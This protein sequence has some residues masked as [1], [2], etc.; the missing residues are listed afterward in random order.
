MPSTY[1]SNLKE[2]I[3]EVKRL[4]ELRDKLDAK[5]NK[6][7]ASIKKSLPNKKQ[8]QQNYKNNLREDRDAHELDRTM[9]KITVIDNKN[10]KRGNHIHKNRNKKNKLNEKIKKH[11]SSIREPR[12]STLKHSKRDGYFIRNR[13]FPKII[14]ADHTLDE[15]ER[16]IKIKYQLALEHLQNKKFKLKMNTIKN[17]RL[18]FGDN[19]GDHVSSVNVY[20]L[21]EIR[22]KLIKKMNEHIVKQEKKK[23]NDEGDEY[24]I[25]LIFIDFFVYNAKN[26][27]G[28]SKKAKPQMIQMISANE[29]IKLYCPK[30][31]GNKCF[32][33][34]LIKGKENKT[35]E[36][37]KRR[38]FDIRRKL[39]IGV[40]KK[41][42][43]SSNEA[44]KIADN[45]GVSYRVY[46]GM[47]KGDRLKGDS[48]DK[49]YK[50]L[51]KYGEEN[52]NTI[53]ILQLLDHCYLIT[54]KKIYN[55]KCEKCGDVRKRGIDCNHKCDKSRVSY[56]QNKI[57]K[58]NTLK[59]RK[60]RKDNSCENWVFYDL[61]TLPCGKGETHLVYAVG[62][63]DCKTSEYLFSYG[64]NSMDEFMEW[65]LKHCDKKYIAFNGCRFDFY[66]L[67]KK[68]L[69]A[70]KTPRFLMSAGRLLSLKWG[71]MCDKKTGEERTGKQNS[72][73][74]KFYENSVWDLYQ[75]MPG[76]SLKSA[77]EAFK[78]EF[79]KQDFDHK[80]MKNWECVEKYKE[81]V[82]H[83]LK[84]DVLSLKELTKK[85][86]NECENLFDA[87]PT[88]YLTLSSYAENV[89]KNNIDDD[90]IIEIPN[91]EKQHFI[92]Q[93]VY[94]GRT[95]PSRKRYESKYCKIIHSNK[96]NKNKLKKI[97]KILKESGDYIFN[98]DIN[99][100]YP[101]CMAGCELMDTIYPIGLSKW[102]DDAVECEKIFNDNKQLGVYEIK[103]SCPNKKIKHPILP[104]KKISVRKNG[105]KIFSGVEWSLLDGQ[106]VYNTVD[107]Q[108]AI[109][110]GYKIEFTGRALIWEG[111]SNKIFH[112]YIT[113]AYNHKTQAKIDKNDVKYQI[114]KL[115]M[116]SL[117]GKTLQNP[118]NKTEKIV[119][120][121]DE[122][123]EF[124]SEHILTDW[125]IVENE[126]N[127]VEY[128]ILTGEKTND[129][130]IDKKPRHLG[131]F[132]LGYSRRLWLLFLETIDPTLTK[133]ITTYQDTDSLH[134]LGKYYKK[135]LK[136]GLIDDKKLG[137]LSND[138]ENNALIF[139]EIN[140]A[141]KCYL[142]L[143]L[144]PDG[145]IHT[146][147][148][149]KGIMKKFLKEEWY[150]DH[151][152]YQKLPD[153]DERK[154]K[155]K[156]KGMK[157][158][159]K[160]ISKN[161]RE[162]GVEHWSIK[163][164]NYSRTFYKN[165]WQH[166]NFVDNHFLPFGHI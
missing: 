106:G 64:K 34:C 90:E 86:V 161:D 162:L 82:L 121:I 126:S 11:K 107:I 129:D 159:N 45:L 55:I 37:C 66:F 142:Y 97:Y 83:Y 104:R 31:S 153:D 54:D 2:E 130:K 131:S 33:M 26:K 140:L 27:V 53:D 147:M 123:E 71:G 43:P 146:T 74:T 6:K 122:T 118:I 89:W 115:M 164:E 58:N 117:Y 62:W 93:S 136:S 5:I 160:N 25:F 38:A 3:E 91:M 61:E 76:F 4:Q 96:S 143:A 99:S 166:M 157:K 80:K 124:V 46:L 87:S 73:D 77:C 152:F 21:D 85:F 165:E 158:I 41:L 16:L 20:N 150:E 56:Y 17:I 98:G 135:L 65:V 156:W 88:M 18:V 67:Q 28:C 116:N 52:E 36:Y 103:F 138:C 154:P 113:L 1:Q 8:L 19:V 100:Q 125:E 79:Q 7:L 81:E 148:K 72:K 132:V 105:K 101:A 92:G 69:E 48:I 23:K 151:E 112:T 110:H 127:E 145:I 108:N 12:F 30:A 14:V 13:V 128:I 44:H 102:Y 137:Y 68:L 109:K 134:I 155:A 94:G 35:N 70:K 111:V 60:L 95:Y 119:K 51:C 84:Y 59:I 133:Y 141:P 63:Y 29:M 49:T 139:K 120:T 22:E 114:A 42:N 78:T 163:Q 149:S 32:D 10:K 57:C 24:D 75:F 40:N 15:I 50:L 144:D 47:I 9:A 39:K